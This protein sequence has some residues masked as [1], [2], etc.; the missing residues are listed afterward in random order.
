[1]SWEQED[2]LRRKTQGY[3]EHCVFKENS[4]LFSRS[5]K[6]KGLLW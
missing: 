5:K 4:E 6:P 1:M 3:C 2:S